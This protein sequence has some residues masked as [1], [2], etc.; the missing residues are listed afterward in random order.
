MN[1]L[2]ECFR[3]QGVQ[4]WLGIKMLN[5][6]IFFEK[7]IRPVHCDLSYQTTITTLQTSRQWNCLRYLK[8]RKIRKSDIYAT[9]PI[10][11]ECRND[12]VIVSECRGSVR[13][14]YLEQL[15]KAGFS[16]VRVIEESAPYEKGKVLVSSW[17]ITSQKPLTK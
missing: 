6:S 1:R 9:E 12:P 8:R 11:E 17:T 5:L 16:S 7:M 13:D 15:R 4:M 3:K 14:E 2:E 10:P